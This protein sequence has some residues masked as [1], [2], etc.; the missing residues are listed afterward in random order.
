MKAEGGNA[1][2]AFARQEAA[3]SQ[4]GREDK[5]V[6]LVWAVLRLAHWSAESTYIGVVISSISANIER[7]GEK[8]S[9]SGESHRCCLDLVR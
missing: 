3:R 5:L 1:G 7:K 2:M 9:P 6:A 8:P 4:G